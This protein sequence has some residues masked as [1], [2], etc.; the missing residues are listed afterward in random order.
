MA[1]P[2]PGPA[3]S[4]SAIAEAPLPAAGADE[5]GHGT[6]LFGRLDDPKLPDAPCDLTRVY[7]GTVGKSSLTLRLALRGAQIE[8]LAHYDLPGPPL[9]LSGSFQ[10]GA[11]EIGRAHV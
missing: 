3:P 8:G 10:G 6:P 1:A 7:R 4:A 11:L 9:A 2:S 5:E